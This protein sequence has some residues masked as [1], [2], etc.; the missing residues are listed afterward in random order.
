MRWELAAL[1]FQRHV[2]QEALGAQGLVAGEQCAAMSFAVRQEVTHDAQGGK[3]Q[4]RGWGQSGA[5]GGIPGYGARRPPARAAEPLAGAHFCLLSLKLRAP[6]SRSTDFPGPLSEQIRSGNG[7]Q[8][9]LVAEGADFGVFE[10]VQGLV[11]AA[12]KA[13]SALPKSPSPAQF[14]EPTPARQGPQWPSTIT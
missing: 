10:E 13:A 12:A 1:G 5:A 7:F 6:S 9:T 4:G 2:A 8:K 3:W 11:L 14:G